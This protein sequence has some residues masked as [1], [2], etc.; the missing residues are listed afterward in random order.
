MVSLFVYF[1]DP[2][3]QPDVRTGKPDPDLEG[4]VMHL[5]GILELRHDIDADERPGK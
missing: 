4:S 3:H 5:F 1:G 2:I